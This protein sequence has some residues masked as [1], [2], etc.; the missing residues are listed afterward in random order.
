MS[1]AAKKDRLT[2]KPSLRLGSV[3]NGFGNPEN[4]RIHRKTHSVLEYECEICSKKF[5]TSSNLKAHLKTHSAPEYECEICSKR[6]TTSSNLN[7]HLK[8]HSEPQYECEFC[9]KKFHAKFNLKVHRDGSINRPLFC[10]VRRQEL[11]T[12]TTK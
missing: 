4:L 7:T 11:A 3:E 2:N 8:T 6:F 9:H 1:T 12:P 10:P 5:A